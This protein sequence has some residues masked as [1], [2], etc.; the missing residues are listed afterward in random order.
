[1]ESKDDED[2]E[3]NETEIAIKESSNN[4]GPTVKDAVIRKKQL[5]NKSN[6][7]KIHTIITKQILPLLFKCITKKSKK[8]EDHKVN[9][10]SSGHY[11]DE[12]VIRVPIVLAILKLLNNLPKRSLE[13]HLPNL[14]LKVC[15]MLKSRAISVRQMTRECLIKMVNSLEK[16]Y[17]FYIF[18][19]LSNSLTRG[20]Q[21]HVLCYT[22]Q[23]LLKH[24]Q[25]K[26]E[27]GDLDSSLAILS[28]VFHAELFSDVSDEKDVKQIVAKV[29]EAK[30]TSSYNSYEIIAKYVSQNCLLELI[31]PLNTVRKV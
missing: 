18:K 25:P 20:Y 6:S 30:T 3:M 24:I 12:Y 31:K 10:K 15:E 14:L 17:Y 28:T 8:D 11:E 21:T 16:K 26:L 23:I 27:V 19:E 4:I 9:K 22:I 13:A 2:I 29:F 7:M 5:V 1:M